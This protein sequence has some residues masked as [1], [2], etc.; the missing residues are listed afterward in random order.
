MK[1]V[2]IM[3]IM[4][5]NRAQRRA[6]AKINGISKIVGSNKPFKHTYPA[7]VAGA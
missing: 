4:G 7:F 6:L 3:T 1:N 5:M 2:D